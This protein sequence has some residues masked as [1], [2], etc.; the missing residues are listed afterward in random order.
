MQMTARP[1]TSAA[2]VRDGR[3]VDRQDERPDQDRG[4]DAAE[5]V[6]RVGR[7][8]H[9]SGHE[10]PRHEQGDERERQRDQE[11]RPP[12][13]LL[14]QEPRHERPERRDGAAEGRPQGNRVRPSRPGR[15]QGRDQREGRR[16]GHAGGDATADAR[17]D[18]HL[19]A[20][21]ERGQQAGRNR[22][23]DAQEEQHLA[24]V[25]VADRPEPQDRCGEAERVADR[26]QVQRGLRGVE[27]G[28]DRRQR[29]VGDREIEVRDGRHE[30]QR[31]EDQLPA[32]GTA[33]SG[34]RASGGR[35][36]RGVG[37]ARVVCHGA[38]PRTIADLPAANPGHRTRD[39]RLGR[40]DPARQIPVSRCEGAVPASVRADHLTHRRR[41]RPSPK[42]GDSAGCARRSMPS[43]ARRPRPWTRR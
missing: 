8:V 20:R 15:P 18:Q 24:A 14:E 13:E 34:W 38:A 2:H 40:E 1:I 3:E 6:D 26:D 39:P 35:R 43:P 36:R 16:V 11:H 30:D 27:R 17:D 7:L 22:E 28:A 21:C 10:P 9:V 12:L 25:S 33:G 32:L 5:V 23:P 37:G 42:P 31:H 41:Y 4:Q 19:D 29:D